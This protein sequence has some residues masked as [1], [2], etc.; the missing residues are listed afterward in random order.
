M[1]KAAGYYLHL[2]LIVTIICAYKN[3]YTNVIIFLFR[4]LQNL[5]CNNQSDFEIKYK[6][7]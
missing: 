1:F 2:K 4:L 7:C 5:S 3:V 6:L